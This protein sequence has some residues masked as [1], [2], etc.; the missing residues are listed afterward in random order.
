MQTVCGASSTLPVGQLLHP[1][2]YSVFASS[3]PCCLA[4]NG[5]ALNF[6]WLLGQVGG[7]S[8][9]SLFVLSLLGLWVIE[10]VVSAVKSNNWREKMPT[11]FGQ[12]APWSLTQ[13]P[14]TIFH[15]RKES[16]SRTAR[17]T[18]DLR[19]KF[20]Q[21]LPSYLLKA[22]L[23]NLSKN[24]GPARVPSISGSHGSEFLCSS[25]LWIYILWHCAPDDTETTLFSMFASGIS[26]GAAPRKGGYV[27]IQFILTVPSK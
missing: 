27:C 18:V 1:P 21:F 25:L 11:C 23:L 13:L 9:L 5:S 10:I 4:P 7:P 16:S 19:G 6:K 17:W 12:R 8:D 14:G 24:R 26:L 2:M 20:V 15:S 22:A 3:I